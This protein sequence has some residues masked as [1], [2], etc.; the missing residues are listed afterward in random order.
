MF[1]LALFL[2]FPLQ[3]YVPMNMLWPIL[4]NK[5]DLEKE[6]TK[7]TWFEYTFKALMVTITCKYLKTKNSFNSID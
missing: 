1:A 7:A 3:F 2:T 5:Y 4:M 6:T